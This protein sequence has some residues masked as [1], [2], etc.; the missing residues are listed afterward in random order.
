MPTTR[1][2]TIRPMRRPII[3]RER[4][5]AAKVPYGQP[6]R[7]SATNAPAPTVIGDGGRSE[8]LWTQPLQGAGGC[9]T[10]ER[11]Y[12]VPRDFE[13]PPCFRCVSHGGIALMASGSMMG[14]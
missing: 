14:E 6:P 8:G 7:G 9:I 13:Q 4:M 5:G 1:H 12:S 2:S 11:T 10:R 3:G